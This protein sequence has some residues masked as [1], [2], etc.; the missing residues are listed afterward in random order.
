MLKSNKLKDSYYETLT[1][2]NLET[3]TIYFCSLFFSLINFDLVLIL[4]KIESWLQVIIFPQVWNPYIH[5]FL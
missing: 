5:G 4:Y 1:K 3:L 2:K